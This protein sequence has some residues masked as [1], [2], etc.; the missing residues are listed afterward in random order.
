[1]KY[2]TQ[3]PYA[4]SYVI[5]K[6]EE[7]KVAFVLRSNTSWMN[8]YYGLPSGKTEIG[9]SFIEGAIREAK[10]EI[11]I[12]VSAD[13]LKHAITVHRYS[14]SGNDQTEDMEWIDVYFEVVS[15]HGEPHNAEPHMH[16]ELTWFDV[17]DLPENTIP[18]V[19]ATFKAL[20][21]GNSYFEYGYNEKDLD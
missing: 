2:G 1:M 9:E 18:S 3:R 15:Y 16:S 14:A 19:T 20:N 13:D 6:N 11:G 21:K 12:D 4:A 5:V 10:E 7:G 8:N 17:D